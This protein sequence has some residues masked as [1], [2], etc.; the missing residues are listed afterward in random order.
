MKKVVLSLAAIISTGSVFAECGEHY[1]ENQKWGAVFNYEFGVTNVTGPREK[2]FPLAAARPLGTVMFTECNRIGTTGELSVFAQGTDG[3]WTALGRIDKEGRPTKAAFADKDV[4]FWYAPKDFVAT[5]IKTVVNVPAETAPEQDGN[6]HARVGGLHIWSNRWFNV[7]QHATAFASS[8]FR[9]APGINDGIVVDWKAWASEPNGKR[10]SRDN[11]Q[12]VGLA[13]PKP[14][15]ISSIAVSYCLFRTAEVQIFVGKGH[16][17]DASDKDWK[18]VKTCNRFRTW[19]PHRSL[20]T[21][22]DLD[23]PVTTRGLRLRIIEPSDPKLDSS[24][25]CLRRSQDGTA[26]QLGELMA[27]GT[28]E[29]ERS[30]RKA[31]AAAQPPEVGIPIAFDMPFDGLATLVIEDKDGKRV[32][33]LVSAQPFK[34]GKNTVLWDGSDDLG[35]DADAARHGL[36]RVPYRAVTPG[37][38][39]VRGLAHEPLKALYE[40]SIYVSG[41]PP[42]VLPDHT[43]AWLS[44]HG[45]PRSALFLPPNRL[46]FGANVSEGTDCIA[47]TDLTG[48][49][50]GGRG[51]VGGNWTGAAFLAQDVG[52]APVTNRDYYV[53]GY[54]WGNA[55][56]KKPPSVRL[57]A[58]KTNGQEERFG[59]I[60]LSLDETPG[61][62]VSGFAV[63]NGT[64]AYAQ[65]SQNLISLTNPVTHAWRQIPVPSPRGLAYEKDG[66]LLVL[67]GNTLVRLGDR[68]KTLFKGLD[69]PFGL[70]ADGN[71]VCIGCRGESHQVW[72]LDLD[73]FFGAKLVRKIGNPGAPKTGVYDEN[74]MN[75]PAGI[76]LDGHGKVWVAERD[77]L[78]KRVSCWDLESGKLVLAKYGPA[79]YGA[80]GM[81]D[82]RDP[83]LF[84]YSEGGGLMEFKVDW[85]AGTSRLNRVLMRPKPGVTGERENEPPQRVVYMPSGKRLYTNCWNAGPCAGSAARLWKEVNDELVLVAA[86]GTNGCGGVSF[87]DGGDIYVHK[88]AHEMKPGDREWVAAYPADAARFR[89]VRF[90]AQ[91]IPVYDFTKP[92][93]LFA[94]ARFSGS[95]GGN[96]MVVDAKGNAFITAPVGDSPSHSVCGGRNGKIL[97][98][99]PNMWPGLHAGHEA[100][101]NSPKGRLVAVTRMLGDCVKVDG[102]DETVVA[103]NGNQGEIYFMTTD[104]FFVDNVLENYERGSRWSFKSLPRGADLTHVSPYDEHFWP[105]VN[106]FED[107]RICLV[108]GKDASSVLR[109]EGLETLR[110]LA[111]SQVTVTAKDILAV[112]DAQ[113]AAEKARRE[114]EGLGTLVCNAGDAPTVD[115]DLAD[116]DL[117]DFV[118]IEN[119]GVAAYFDSNSKP[120]DIRGGLRATKT[121]LYAAWKCEGVRD[122]ARNSG[123]NAELQFKTGG[124]CDL[125]LRTD[126]LA[127]GDRPQPGDVRILASLVPGA[128]DGRGNITKWVPRVM[129]Y[130]QKAKGAEAAKRVPFESP[131][132][133]VDFDRVEDVT[134]KC[135]FV[136]G[137]TGDYELEVPLEVVGFKPKMG[138]KTLGDIG[139]LRGADGATIARLYWANKATGIVSDVPSEAMLVPKSW[140]PVEV[141]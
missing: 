139:V 56:E 55:K 67:S 47:Y 116:W 22:L 117:A 3:Q 26:V 41:N 110:R 120:Y 118:T 99:Y 100:P 44:N 76:C 45:E 13:W 135:R 29:A 108:A 81:F 6:F 53:C 137:K 51:W 74:H 32:R 12:S 106:R 21:L 18:T 9:S 35:R 4:S 125:M 107:G 15:E 57:T 54:V 24:P 33:N 122:L 34:K 8:G 85:A 91:G 75:N 72:V 48:R 11:A 73:G 136:Q 78:P 141:R 115:G 39:R 27:L 127:K 70:A 121:H 97:W 59:D 79:K 111:D 16:P 113:A 129:L 52:D 80:G 42:W 36:Y 82:P 31:F 69:D 98:S 86:Y 37:E 124:A 128:K 65:E 89:P 40:F 46:L 71:L 38:Y 7:S 112:Q 62:E 138:L 17:K 43:G 23:R 28:M 60:P 63:W 130:E 84:Y 5:A 83:S 30:A 88:L 95:S 131:V 64:I 114:V 20:L 77:Y 19:L 102:T 14:V 96:Q 109:V 61:R 49:K 58:I 133:K 94:N 132:M 105:T 50:T 123:E 134:D 119:R 140:G 104:G 1:P 101:R 103:I 25:N 90:D 92:E 2:V 68:T 87:V 10:I 66:S 93:S 126:P